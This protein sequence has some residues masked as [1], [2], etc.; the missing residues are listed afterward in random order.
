MLER[1]QARTDAKTVTRIAGLIGREDQGTVC[2]QAGNGVSVCREYDRLIF[3]CGTPD[4]DPGEFACRI[5]VPGEC[6]IPELGV[7][8]RS[9]AVSLSRDLYTRILNNPDRTVAYLK[10]SAVRDGLFTVRTWRDGDTFYPLGSPG[11]KKLQDFFTDE[12]VPAAHRRRVPILESGG[13]ILWV[14]GMRISE[15]AKVAPGAGEAVRI[16]AGRL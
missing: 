9:T 8:L 7:V 1:T 3:S 14:V 13:E 2:E 5:G 15:R 12:K 4:R 16:E 10:S 6:R 11:E